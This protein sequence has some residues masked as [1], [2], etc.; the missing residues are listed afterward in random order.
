NSDA[1]CRALAACETWVAWRVSCNA[2]ICFC[3]RTRRLR[4]SARPVMS[5][6]Y[7]RRQEAV[8]EQRQH[9]ADT[10]IEKRKRADDDE[11]QRHEID[12]DLRRQLVDE[13]DG[14]VGED[15]IGDEGAGETQGQVERLRHGVGDVDQRALRVEE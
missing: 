8:A 12:R 3:R 10:E 13:A 7:R 14:E 6:A 5:A 1:A 2:L 4:R 9:E 11:G 15:G